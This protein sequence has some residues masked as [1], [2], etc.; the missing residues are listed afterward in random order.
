MQACTHGLY[1]HT[2]RALRDTD[3]SHRAER[4]LTD[5]RVTGVGGTWTT[6]KV[7]N[8]GSV[9]S[10]CQRR[11]TPEREKMAPR[12]QSKSKAV[13]E[14]EEAKIKRGK[15][16][17]RKHKPSANNNHDLILTETKG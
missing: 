6:N 13:M 2:V 12:E 5:L 8:E 7:Q 11:K 15:E 4:A 14:E 9:L 3:G 17:A 1:A 10:A 16:E